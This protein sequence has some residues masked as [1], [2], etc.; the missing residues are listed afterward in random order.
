MTSETN[1]IENSRIF[2]TE[3]ETKNSSETEQLNRFV[4]GPLLWRIFHK[5]CEYQVKIQK[6]PGT[7]TPREQLSIS[8]NIWNVIRRLM[9]TIPC[10]SCREHSI[11]EHS[12]S[13]KLI[14]TQ[15]QG[16]R[17]WINEFHN[18]VN[19]RLGR[20]EWHENSVLAWV[21]T[22]KLLETFEDYMK[23]IQYPDNSTIKSKLRE[24]IQKFI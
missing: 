23:A 19:I 7:M 11:Y 5:L 17:S 18:K 13:S 2:E 22:V 24:D 14:L 20:K 1:R 12:I 9:E 3:T 21:S 10:L 15:P 4:W 6:H 8:T 16:L